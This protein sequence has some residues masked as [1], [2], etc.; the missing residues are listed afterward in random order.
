[1]DVQSIC[2]LLVRYDQ[3]SLCIE[4]QLW[5]LSPLHPSPVGTVRGALELKSHFSTLHL[6]HALLAKIAQLIPVQHDTHRI[7][8]ILLHLNWVFK[9]HRK[10]TA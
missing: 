7:K 8:G 9:P 2:P 10:C 6:R 1:M 4:Y 3:F 5:D